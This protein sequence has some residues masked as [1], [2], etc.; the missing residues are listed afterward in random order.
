MVCCNSSFIKINEN[1]A[2]KRVFDVINIFWLMKTLMPNGTEYVLNWLCTF[3]K[4][5]PP[6][7]KAHQDAKVIFTISSRNSLLS[8]Y[9]CVTTRN[10][11]SQTWYCITYILNVTCSRAFCDLLSF[12]ASLKLV[13]VKY[14]LISIW[15][16]FCTGCNSN[17]CTAYVCKIWPLKFYKTFFKLR[18]E[19]IYI[20]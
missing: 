3:I 6:F 4:L 7:C 12:W 19:S 8:F 9:S 20:F 11:C 14:E 13:A 18:K 17:L 5:V 2:P 1:F 15:P 10:F 16:P